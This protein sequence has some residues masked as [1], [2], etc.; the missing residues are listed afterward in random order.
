MGAPQGTDRLVLFTDAVVAI[1]IT[2]LV[3]PLV[4]IAREAV[5]TG[6]PSVELIT[7]N[8]PAIFSFLL[9][10]V[11]IARFWWV[12]HQ[13]FASVTVASTAIVVWNFVW[14]LTIVLLPF[15]TEMVSGYDNDQFTLV[16][17]IAMIL[18][19]SV[20][21]TAMSTL[22]HGGLASAAA[23][24]TGLLVVALVLA[25]LVP[26]VGYFWLLLLFLSSL[27]ERLLTRLRGAQGL[28]SG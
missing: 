26:A 20:C 14:V 28:T 1:A 7:E 2:L 10:F 17:Y 21:L 15:V 16:L 18:A 4:D 23:A 19:G 22:A 3:L 13:L 24:A 5:A 11:V 8:W 6:A 27:V 12:H 25:L 9:S